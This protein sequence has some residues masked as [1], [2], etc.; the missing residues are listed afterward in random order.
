MFENAGQ[1][2]RALK[3]AAKSAGGN[4]GD[5]YRQ[6]LRDRFLCR[7]FSDP[8]GRFVLKGGSGLL[9]RIPTARPASG[10]AVRNYGTPAQRLSLVED[11]GSC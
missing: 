10:Q 11:E 3:K 8:D 2:D 6:A 1:F 9:A 7:V 5:K 4:V